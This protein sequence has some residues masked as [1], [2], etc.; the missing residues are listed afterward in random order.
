MQ[1]KSFKRFAAVAMAATLCVPAFSTQVLADEIKTD[2]GVY[3]PVLTISVPANASIKV[4]S[5]AASGSTDVDSFTVAS[6]SIDILNATTDLEKNVGVPL[7]VTVQARITAKG[8]DVI[9]EYNS[10]TVDPISPKKQIHLELTQSKAVTAALATGK[11][12]TLDADKKLVL[13]PENYTITGKDYTAPITKMVVTEYG[14]KISVDVG[15]PKTTATDTAGAAD[16]FAKNP[17]LIVPGAS[18]FAVVGTANTGANW[19]ADDLA[20]ELIY[21]AKASNPLSITDTPAVASAPTYSAASPANVEVAVA[22][23]GTAT[24]AGIALHAPELSTSDFIFEGYTVAYAT[25]S[26]KTTATITI[27]KDDPILT[28]TRDLGT[29]TYDIVVALTDGRI[30]VTTL[31]VTG[32]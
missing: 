31:A 7:N 21:N 5:I 11:T 22:D 6:G 23:V 29:E 30:A 12:P 19:K 3:A 24:V 2:F 26:G 17:E 8:S 13:D 18:S 27:D 10:F 28:A 16:K 4:N 15:E 14:S 9:T 32:K 1:F 20:V 25:A